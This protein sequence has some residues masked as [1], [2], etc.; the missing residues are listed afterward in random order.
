[1][2]PATVTSLARGLDVLFAL[3]GGA[4]A[5]AARIADGLGR[6][7]SQVS[8]VL[9]TLAASPFVE[10]DAGSREYRLSWQLDVLAQ[11]VSATR[12]LRAGRQ[13]AQELTRR[14]GEVAGVTVLRGD[15]TVALVESV[16]RDAPHLTSWVGR[17][18]PAYCSDS[19]QALL[20]DATLGALEEIFARTEWTLHT[21]NTPRS[22]GD[23]HT[24][25]AEARARGYA[26]I[27]GEAAP[28]HVAVCAPVRGFRGEIVAGLFVAGP[29]SH[30]RLREAATQIGEDVAGLAAELSGTLGWPGPAA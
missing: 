11:R 13:T 15:A 27:D 22:I 6:D 8:R 14:T 17:A 10:R 24:R 20:F 2:S 23:L 19:G 12:L 5:G 1:M 25:I 3:D 9:R 26:V 21:A 18:F 30:E 29:P 16:P 28:D 7:R 4:G